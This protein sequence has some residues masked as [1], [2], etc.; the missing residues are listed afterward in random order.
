[1]DYIFSVTG[2]G[3]RV[4]RDAISQRLWPGPEQQTVQIQHPQSG[5]TDNIVHFNSGLSNTLFTVTTQFWVIRQLP[6]GNRTSDACVPPE[7]RDES[8]LKFAQF[9]LFSLP[10]YSTY[11]VVHMFGSRDKQQE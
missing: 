6:R 4:V 2:S 3:A 7:S 11:V 1:M 5:T 9:L 10:E 8:P